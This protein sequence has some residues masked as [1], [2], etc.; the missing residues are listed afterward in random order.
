MITSIS[1][2]QTGGALVQLFSQLEDQ[3]VAPPTQTLFW[4]QTYSIVL[5]GLFTFIVLFGATFIPTRQ[6]Q[7]ILKVVKLLS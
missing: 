1:K 3:Q 6:I 7:L 5:Q 4:R 2:E